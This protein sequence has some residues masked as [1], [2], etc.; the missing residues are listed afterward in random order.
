[1]NR[2]FCLAVLSAALVAT[3]ACA[4]TP[5]SPAQTA[6]APAVSTVAGY[7]GL[8]SPTSPAP[9]YPGAATNDTPAPSTP[10]PATPTSDPKLGSVAGVI[11]LKGKPVTN[12]AIYLGQLLKDNSGTESVV[13]L[14]PKASPWAPTDSEGHFRIVNVAP[15]R[16]GLVLVTVTSSV[17]L[18]YP[19]KNESVIVTIEA[20]K[21]VDLGVLNYAALPVPPG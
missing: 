16:Y 18:L 9:G 7:P 17:H 8:P 15:G 21:E 3:S 19:D 14:D 20:G 5:T 13:A 4:G 11:Q 1:M 6:T 2:I 10:L 12:V